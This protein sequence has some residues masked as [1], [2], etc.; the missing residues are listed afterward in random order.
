MN[1]QA[2]RAD[3]IKGSFPSLILSV[4]ASSG[5]SSKS[6][7]PAA[8]PAPV[9]ETV[10]AE[11]VPAAKRRRMTP[12]IMI[13][14]IFLMTV[15]GAVVAFSRF[16][17]DLRNRPEYQFRM[18]ESRI[19]PPPAW[20][21]AGIL[22]EVMADAPLPETVSL[23]D[24]DL[25]RNVA[26]AWER[27]PWV[28]RVLCVQ[29]TSEP[30]LV[31]DVEYRQPAALI[32]VVD[33]FYP[34]DQDGILLPPRDFSSTSTELLP[35]VQNIVSTPHDGVGKPW[36]DP[37]VVAV[38]KLAAV[39]A[40]EQNLALYWN[41]FQLKSIIAPTLSNPAAA[42]DQL[43]FELETAGGNRVVWG[44]PPGE[45]SLEPTPEVKLARLVEYQSRFGSLDGV[46]GRHRIDIR[47][48]DG[49]SLHPLGVIR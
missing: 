5:K 45:D 11:I 24:P 7:Q 22:K 8:S 14:L 44:R 39:L 33:G 16:V 31:V 46:S 43:I 1:P 12:G 17:P 28:K 23:L 26:R 9:P 3:V 15:A 41:R 49:I 32:R 42:P 25:C 2:D 38:A 34:V 37:V 36:G 6:R 35:Q 48:F 30:A 4:M 13:P 20:V 47:L 40:P 21:P 18:E 29:I 19:T 10:E 27:H